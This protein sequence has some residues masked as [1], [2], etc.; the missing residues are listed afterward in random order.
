MRKLPVDLD[1]L[2]L[3]LEAGREVFDYF[4]DLETGATIMVTEETSGQLEELYELAGEQDPEAEI[5][6]P[7]LMAA[8]GIEDWEAE[9]LL[10]ADRVER[11]FGVS[12]VRV[13]QTE[14]REGYRD[15]E[16]FIDTVEDAHLADLLAVAIQGRGAFRRFKDVLLDHESERQRWFA[17]KDRRA[18]QRVVEWLE[19]HGIEPIVEDDDP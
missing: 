12:I 5:D 14:S 15:M 2:A 3:A 9:L 4:F 19:S 18:E 8:E 7:A 16:A 6:L 13:P 17:F 11:E 1:E 10:D